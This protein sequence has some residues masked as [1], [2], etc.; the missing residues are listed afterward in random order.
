MCIFDI[1]HFKHINDTFGHP[2]GDQVLYL[3]ANHAQRALRSPDLLAR[4]GGEEFVVVM[5]QTLIA[6]AV[7]VI[8]RLHVA[9]A[10]DE[11]WAERPELKVTFSAGIAALNV[12]ESMEDAVARADVAL[13]RAKQSG[14]NCTMVAD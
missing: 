8:E 3:L 9:L 1:D 14:R 4:W 11:I 12:A 13:Y 2:A 7:V 6:D 5:P 10:R